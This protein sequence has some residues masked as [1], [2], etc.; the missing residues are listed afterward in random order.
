MKHLFL[1]EKSEPTQPWVKKGANK[2]KG[3]KR[4]GKETVHGRY[5]M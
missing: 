3:G 4:Y 2:E 5:D 1:S